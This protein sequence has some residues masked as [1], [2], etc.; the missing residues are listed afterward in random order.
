M[1]ELTVYIHLGNIKIPT[2]ITICVI[3]TFDMKQE[4]FQPMVNRT[5]PK[6]L[7]PRG[8]YPKMKQVSSLS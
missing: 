3:R 2:K 1:M 7:G 6:G 5:L 8:E 4:G